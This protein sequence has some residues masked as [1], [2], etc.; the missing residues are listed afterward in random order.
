M[1]QEQFLQ[2]L[3]R[4]YELIKE[5]TALINSLY[6]LINNDKKEECKLLKNALKICKLKPTKQNK[7]AILSRFINLR[8]DMVVT[9]LEQNGKSKDEIKKG[10]LLLLLVL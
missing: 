6:S 1:Q 2:D 8:E 3:K 9:A 10:F 7:I 4:V 5:R